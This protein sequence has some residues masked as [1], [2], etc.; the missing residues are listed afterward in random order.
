[1]SINNF[2]NHFKLND[3][4]ELLKYFPRDK[5][6]LKEVL[7]SKINRLVHFFQTGVLINEDKICEWAAV[8]A[9]DKLSNLFEGV[10][11]QRKL[12]R[13]EN[14]MVLKKTHILESLQNAVK[15]IFEFI[16][17]PTTVGAILPSSKGLAKEIVKQFP[18]DLKAKPRLI[19]EVGPGTGV[20]TD[21]I[22]KRMNPGDELHLVEYDENFC[23]KLREKYKDIP[24]VKIF[25]MS[26][27]EYKDEQ[28]RKYDFVISGLPL[29]A[30]TSDFV[31]NVF[32][33]FKEITK[34][35]GKISYFEY[36]IV[37][38]IKKIF[39]NASNKQNLESI[40][41][42]KEKFYSQYKLKK[43]TV[44]MNLPLARVV[45]HHYNK[46]DLS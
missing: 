38:Q 36:L 24:N 33:K 40:L 4:N 39:S 22:V 34:N 15:F 29:N 3:Q 45:H 5:H 25:Q 44:F 23:K 11:V 35:D 27:L 46:T 28:D 14:N 8:H 31:E 16:D 12:I 9:D 26:I 6:N 1:M 37:P 7:I 2:S 18:K 30:F 13:H 20:F 43:A 19:L 32:N 42:M 17:H 21:E 10:S 41:D